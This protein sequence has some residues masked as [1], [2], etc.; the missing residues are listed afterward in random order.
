MKRLTAVTRKKLAKVSAR[1]IPKCF[2]SWPLRRSSLPEASIREG[3]LKMNAL[4]IPARE[5]ISQRIIKNIK[6]AERT[7]QT[8]YVVLFFSYIEAV[9][10]KFH[11]S[12]F[13]SFHI[14]LKYS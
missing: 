14:W 4:I 13:N 6:K 9:L 12:A 1:V 5:V 2:K 10:L 3:L 11:S 8:A 7:G